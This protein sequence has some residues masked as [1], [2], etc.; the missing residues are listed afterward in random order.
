VSWL[1]ES[2][3]G[4]FAREEIA[5]AMNRLDSTAAIAL[6]W[7]CY[8]ARAYE[9]ACSLFL[10]HLPADLDN[11][12]Y[13]V[14]LET[15]ARRSSRIEQVLE[16]YQPHT[17]QAPHLYGRREALSPLLADRRESTASRTG[18]GSVSMA[19][20]ARP[21]PS[22]RLASSAYR[23]E[24]RG[25]RPN[26]GRMEAAPRSDRAYRGAPRGLVGM[27]EALGQVSSPPGITSTLV[28]E[29]VLQ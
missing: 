3:Q 11:R 20:Y 27:R 15:A 26:P 19:P 9:L 2:G 28:Y 6:A 13:L 10:E 14:A 16:A 25:R 22:S 24:D 5:S 1:F 18:P 29:K 17:V 8:T 21:R 12:K 4:P 7:V 23:H